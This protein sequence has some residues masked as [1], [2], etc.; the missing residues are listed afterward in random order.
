[1]MEHILPIRRRRRRMFARKLFALYPVLS[2]HGNL[3]DASMETLVKAL[4]ATSLHPF[5][6]AN[7]TILEVD[8][9]D[10]K[11]ARNE[12]DVIEE[13][14]QAITPSTSTAYFTIR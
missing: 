13:T 12:E 1:M 8:A 9:R 3:E 5:H 4:L 14:D 11:A 2:A 10:R 6:M 7:L